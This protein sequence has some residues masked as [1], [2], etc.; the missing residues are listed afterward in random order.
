MKYKTSIVPYLFL[1]LFYI[2]YS[3]ANTRNCY[4]LIPVADP[5]YSQ[6]ISLLGLEVNGSLTFEKI[7]N[8]FGDA[9]SYKEG[10]AHDS[11]EELCYKSI[12]S[13]HAIIFSSQEGVINKLLILSDY[14]KYE[15]SKICKSSQK[16]TPSIRIGKHIGFHLTRNNL[17]RL[18]M[19]GMTKDEISYK[20]FSKNTSEDL[21][22]EVITFNYNFTFSF[23]DET[24]EKIILE[25]RSTGIY[26]Q[27]CIR[28]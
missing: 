12:D 9:I 10:D 8:K 16:I 28:N 24:I 23:A 2:Q 18:G 19:G 6:N 1:T 26:K 13:S 27:D 4:P 25:N 7:K 21:I 20:H 11:I 22:G 17:W 14:N 3:F 5:A 15:N